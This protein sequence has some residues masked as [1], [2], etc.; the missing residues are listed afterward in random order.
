MAMVQMTGCPRLYSLAQI[1]AVYQVV[2][3]CNVSV[4]SLSINYSGRFQ[5][6]ILQLTAVYL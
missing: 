3:V 1:M 2:T 4:F 5:S 6:I